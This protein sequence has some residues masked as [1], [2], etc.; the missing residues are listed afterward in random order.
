MT[1]TGC[2]MFLSSLIFGILSV[3]IGVGPVLV[4]YPNA[5]DSYVSEVVVAFIANMEEA[6]AFKSPIN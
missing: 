5:G 1:A 3:K 6:G 4:D 2:L